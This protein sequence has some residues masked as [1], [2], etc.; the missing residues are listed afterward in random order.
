[1]AKRLLIEP[2]DAELSIRR[3]CEL[4]ELNR[5]TYYYQ[6]ATETALNLELMRLIDE[7]Y[8]E[9]PIY[10]R[11]KMTIYLRQQ[12]YDVNPKRIRRLLQKMGLEAIYPK[13]RTS[14]VNQAHKIYPYLLRG[15][16]ITRPNQVWSTDIT[17]IRMQ[18]GFMY[19][20]AVIDWYSR[21]VLSWQLSNTLDT[22][23][24]VEAL[25][26]ALQTGRPEIFN[27]DQ[28]AQF[29]ASA[30]TSVLEEAQIQISM[31]GKGRA[32]DNIMVERLWRTV[33]YEDIYLHEYAT[34]PALYTGMDNYFRFYNHER[35]HQSLAYATPA[36]VHQAA[37]R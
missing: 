32:L 24:C 9:R 19:L 35:P 30:F 26:Q 22:A 5:S 31:D 4:L 3:Q 17:Y 8:T 28:G 33:K 13:P 20:V 27:T 21:Y 1:M 14:V 18:K 23:F 7:K 16:K 25:Q 10:G 29:T 6:P 15:L 34:V 36:V 2:G 11:R 37:F 12:G